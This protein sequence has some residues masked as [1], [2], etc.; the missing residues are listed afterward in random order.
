LRSCFWRPPFTLRQSRSE[1][2]PLNLLNGTGGGIT[3]YFP[4]QTFSLAGGI[5][6]GHAVVGLSDS[7]TYRG[8]GFTLGDKI[9]G[10]SFDGTGLAV[11]NRGLA[12][13]RSSQSEQM[14]AFVGETGF[15]YYAPFFQGAIPRHFGAG[16]FLQKRIGRLQ[17]SSLEVLDGSKRTAAEGFAYQRRIFRIAGNGGLLNSSRYLNGLADLEPARFLH[18]AAMHQNYFAPQRATFDN[19]S[20]FTSFW[21]LTAQASALRGVSVGQKITGE[22]FGA[23]AHFA[24][25]SEYSDFYRSGRQRFLTHTVLE[26]FRRVRFSQTVTQ[27]AGRNSFSF[28]GGYHGN[29]F[30]ADVTHSVLFF[31]L[32]GRGFQQ[33]L[34][35]QV[36]FRVPHTDAAVNLGTNVDP[37]GR[38]RYTAYGSEYLYGNS[39]L[40]SGNEQRRSIGKYLISGTVLDELGTPVEGAALRVGKAFLLTDSQ[41]AFSLRTNKPKVFSVQVLPQEFLLGNYE[42]ISSPAQTQADHTPEPILIVVRRR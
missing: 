25:L 33:V 17:L 31:V 8:Y 16:L 32:N 1:R 23:G 2:V 35:V 36:S 34:N 10:F 20:A 21:H 19:L 37:T 18:F 7:F 42:V 5:G 29:S 11:V 27:S 24:W 30:S 3:A 6:Q 38:L 39:G 22:S 13:S 26:N 4:T 28:D 41:G 14:T 40:F 12:V 9:L 15:G